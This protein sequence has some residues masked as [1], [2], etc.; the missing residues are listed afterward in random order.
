[1]LAFV[2]LP[3]A[4]HYADE[5]LQRE[6]SDLLTLSD[7]EEEETEFIMGDRGSALSSRIH[8]ALRRKAAALRKVLDSSLEAL[9][10]TVSLCRYRLYR[11]DT[12]LFC[13]CLWLLGTKQEGSKQ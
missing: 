10:S 4:Y 2:G 1:M 5:V 8:G 11:W 13:F 7:D 12:L 3:L 6:E 9:K